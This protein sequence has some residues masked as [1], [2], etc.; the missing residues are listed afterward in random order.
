MSTEGKFLLL[1]EAML[2]KSKLD[3]SSVASA[4]G[5]LYVQ[6]VASHL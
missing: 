5:E 2:H 6:T 3:S 4:I 1:C